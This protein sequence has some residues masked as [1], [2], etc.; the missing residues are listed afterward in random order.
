MVQARRYKR[1]QVRIKRSDA[2]KGADD[3]AA[4]LAAVILR[5]LSQHD[6]A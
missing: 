3:N 5:L 6:D 4:R 1:E 2:L